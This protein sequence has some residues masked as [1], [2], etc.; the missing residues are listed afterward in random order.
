MFFQLQFFSL[1]W[2]F[3]SIFVLLSKNG[4]TLPFFFLF[5]LKSFH[6]N[7]SLSFLF[8]HQNLADIFSSNFHSAHFRS[9]INKVGKSSLCFDY[10]LGLL[11][12]FLTLSLSL[13]LSLSL[14]LFILSLLLSFSSYFSYIYLSSF[15]K[16]FVFLL[17]PK[18]Q[19]ISKTK[20][21]LNIFLSIIDIVLTLSQ[22][23]AF[24]GIFWFSLIFGKL[25]LPSLFLDQLK[26]WNNLWSHKGKWLIIY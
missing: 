4:F 3:N 11:S 17:S 16:P 10:H 6:F 20:V 12:L 9:D 21:I 5:T 24:L 25:I 23:L 18:S 2:L 26:L 22:L 13:S 8:V 19:K 15:I 14:F 7:S 1:F